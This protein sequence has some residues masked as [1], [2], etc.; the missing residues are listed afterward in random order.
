[1]ASAVGKFERAIGSSYCQCKLTLR[2]TTHHEEIVLDVRPGQ[3]RLARE[4]VAGKRAGKAQG[5]RQQ[6]A[7]RIHRIRPLC[8]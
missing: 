2:T 5:D 8:M 1:M 7:Q 3:W 4:L 6:V